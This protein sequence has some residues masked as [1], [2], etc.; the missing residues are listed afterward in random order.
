MS[1]DPLDEV[2]AAFREEGRDLVDALTAQLL[3]L[4]GAPPEGRAPLLKEMMRGMHNLKGAA[5][6][7]GLN[8]TSYL[9]HGVESVLLLLEA[10]PDRAAG[11]DLL[12]RATDALRASLGDRRMSEEGAQVLEALKAQ[13]QAKGDAAPGV[14]QP[15]SSAPPDL[16]QASSP[17]VTHVTSVGRRGP[18]P[19]PER[20]DSLRVPMT[21]LASLSL[22]ASEVAL[23]LEG[24]RARTRELRVMAGLLSGA[25]EDVGRQLG[26]GAPSSLRLR[27]VHLGLV[28]ALNRFEFDALRDSLLGQSLHSAL[29]ALRLRSL[30]TVFRVFPRMARDLARS[31]GKEV[32]VTLSGGA[33][34]IEK[35]LIDL[36]RDALTHLVRN[37]LDHG[38]EAPAGRVAVGKP[39]AGQLH[40]SARLL[41]TWLVIEVTD[42]GGGIDERK[43]LA[44]AVERKVVTQAEA[45]KMSA[46]LAQDLI[47]HAGLSTRQSVSEISGRGVGLD[48]VRTEVERNGGTVRVSGTLGKETTFTIQLPL[49][50]HRSHVLVVR[51][52]TEHLALPT[53]SVWKVANLAPTQLVSVGGLPSLEIEGVHVPVVELGPLVGVTRAQERLGA[54]PLV[55][56]RS[57]GRAVAC[58]VDELLFDEEIVV[59]EVEPPLQ[60]PSFISGVAVRTN[61]EVLCILN[62]G[63]LVRLAGVH[64]PLPA[65]LA[66]ATVAPRARRVLIVDDSF[67]IRTLE[68]SILELAGY[69]VLS[70]SDGEEA[71]STLSREPVDLIVSDINMPRRDG[72]ELLAAVRQSPRLRDLPFILVTSRASDADKRRGLELGANAY[73]VKSEFDQEVLVDA[74]SRLA[75]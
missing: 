17:D 21:T 66:P 23:R 65:P 20:E 33:I 42:D 9:A 53:A 8:P 3:K 32:V 34:E 50:A 15:S 2:R 18:A 12:Q 63:E 10:Q 44:A 22:E 59:R 11:F 7:L 51:V 24:A 43:V 71:L 4:E 45:A 74:V 49:Q 16:K 56:L 47:F 39:A 68:K 70:A 64:A 67:T 58:A 35:G 19:D 6:S 30:S 46:E 75:G 26:T 25:V 60:T 5:S 29:R 72:F 38:I 61:G 55:A 41:D 69:T 57:Q 28:Q 48:A 52:G 36:L 62:P 40:L 73:V 27:E 13:V 37:S 54:T 14:K 1:E 31:L